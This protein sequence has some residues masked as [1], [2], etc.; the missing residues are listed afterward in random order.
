[1]KS[2]S[3]MMVTV[4]GSKV[5]SPATGRTR[6]L[7]GTGI[8]PKFD[9]GISA[10]LTRNGILSDTSVKFIPSSSGKAISTSNRLALAPPPANLD[11]KL[12]YVS[13][14]KCCLFSF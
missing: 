13:L 4:Q 10:A 6:P 9:A 3:L 11:S 12:C 8:L 1:M 2:V 5:R 7:Y 14:I